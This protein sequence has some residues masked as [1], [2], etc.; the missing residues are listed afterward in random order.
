M[1]QEIYQM[2]L[3]HLIVPES[4]E[5]LKTPTMMVVFPRDRVA[6]RAPRAKTGIILATK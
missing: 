2:S 3:E 5:V 1:R 4:K 6:F